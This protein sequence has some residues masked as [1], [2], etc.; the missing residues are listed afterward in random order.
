MAKARRF[1]YHRS[2]AYERVEVPEA[3]MRFAMQRVTYLETRA[4]HETLNYLLACAYLQGINDCVEAHVRN[5]HL[6]LE[7]LEGVVWG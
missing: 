4:L 1:V 7:A 2:P 5:P 3:S 6:A